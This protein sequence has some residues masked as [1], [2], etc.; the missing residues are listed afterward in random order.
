[1]ES[2]DAA[3]S[4][5]CTYLF[6]YT[7]PTDLKRLHGDYLHKS[8]KGMVAYWPFYGAAGTLELVWADEF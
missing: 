4:H 5:A 3:L 2:H 8:V 1:M 7:E 6:I